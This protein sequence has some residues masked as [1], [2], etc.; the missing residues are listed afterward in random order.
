MAVMLMD[1]LAFL[2]GE[3]FGY[4]ASSLRS[5][6]D[7]ET[8]DDVLLDENDTCELLRNLEMVLQGGLLSP[9]TYL[10]KLADIQHRDS[11]VKTKDLETTGKR[12]PDRS[13]ASVPQVLQALEAVRLAAARNLSRSTVS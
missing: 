8:D 9:S 12:L 1:S 3:S 11:T 10:R 2:E 5:A 6:D 13:E 4:S 7:R